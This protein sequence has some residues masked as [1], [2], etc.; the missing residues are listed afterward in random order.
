M[1]GTRDKYEIYHIDTDTKLAT[2]GI[3]DDYKGIVKE[4]LKDLP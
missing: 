3:E 2:I 1:N 4:L